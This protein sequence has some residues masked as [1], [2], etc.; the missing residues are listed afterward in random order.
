MTIQK[1]LSYALALACS[2]HLSAINAAA[3][4]PRETSENIRF[5][6]NTVVP[7]TIGVAVT[8]YY[9]YH[10]QQEQKKTQDLANQ[11]VGLKK[12]R[13]KHVESQDRYQESQAEQAMVRI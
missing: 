3:P 6:L 8:V 2:L 4:K 11:L 7:V 12:I 5:F 9:Y 13:D 1:K 10:Y